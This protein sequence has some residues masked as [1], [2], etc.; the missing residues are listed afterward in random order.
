M[1]AALLANLNSAKVDYLILGGGAVCLHGFP[2]M[3][4][5][6]D[7]LLRNE[8]GNVARFV[9]VASQ[10]GDG[11]AAGLRYEDFQGPGCIRIVESFPLDVFTL[12]DGRKYEDFAPSA[13]SYIL[14]EGLQVRCLSIS[15]LIDLKKKT[16]REKDR[17]DVEVLRRLAVNPSTGAG[18]NINLAGPEELAAK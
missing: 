6:I 16:L 4:Y 11:H 15:D 1:Y 17:V 12:L 13:V 5:D 9:N 10:W 7:I 18:R 8:T 14:Q 2:R 3:T